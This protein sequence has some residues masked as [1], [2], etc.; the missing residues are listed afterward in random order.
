[1][2]AVRLPPHPTL[3]LPDEA[4][5]IR[6][7][8]PPI[9]VLGALAL[10][11]IVAAACGDAIGPAVGVEGTYE[12]HTINGEAPPVTVYEEEDP[13]EGMTFTFDVAGGSLQLAGGGEFLMTLG[14]QVRANGTLVAADTETW[15]GSY[16]VDGTTITFTDPEGDVVV[17]QIDGDAIVF[18]E[19]DD[20]TGIAME[21]VFRR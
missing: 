19:V 17:G 4:A 16:Q 5:M 8:T 13:V 2:L 9:R 15:S 6:T 11:L 18:T 14:W 20:E 3:H 1:M 7:V 12:L 21:L 10:A